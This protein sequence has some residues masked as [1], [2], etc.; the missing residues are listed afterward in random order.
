MRK[1][2]FLAGLLAAVAFLSGCA[3]TAEVTRGFAMD[4]A[5]SITLYGDEIRAADL[6]KDIAA[7]ENE[8]SWN[9]DT[10]AVSALNRD[11]QV[12]N[13]LLADA[14]KKLLPICEKSGGEYRLLM[15]PLC[16]LWDVT[17]ENPALPEKAQIE[18]A[19][20]LCKGRV[21]AEGDRVILPDGGRMDLG[22]VG[23]G[24]ACDL[25]YDRLKAVD[26][27]G[28]IAL[29]GSI[30]A[31]GKKPTGGDWKINLASP[32][33][34]N[35]TL[36][37]LSVKGGEFVSTSGNGE[38]YFEVDNKRYHHIL[39]G[40]SGY[41]SETGLDSVTVVCGEGIVADAL[42]TVC[43]LLGEERSLSLLEEYNAKAVFVRSDG[44]LRVTDGL[45][46]KFEVKK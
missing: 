10:S 46:D 19:L 11:G 24:I 37:V 9:V 14:V 1:F 39:S 34:R 6:L 16:E 3:P 21:E 25:L 45:R 30:V 4:T 7:L 22:S 17:A 13:A 32:D 43:F 26:G 5:V 31:C 18:A 35:K 42:S 15:R 23:K 44:S 12:E 41:P 36:G 2:R 27:V 20:A 8:L 38:R 28:V 40:L 29:G 33:D